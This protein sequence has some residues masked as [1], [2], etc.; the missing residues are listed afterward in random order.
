MK[1]ILFHG[2]GQDNKSWDIVK[3]YFKENKKEVICPNLFDI[4]K[5]IVMSMKIYIGILKNK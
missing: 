4:L 2:L 3:E 5:I 1:N